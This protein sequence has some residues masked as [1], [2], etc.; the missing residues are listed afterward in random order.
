MERL[1]GQL[2]VVDMK[3]TTLRRGGR[4]G[5]L[6]LVSRDLTRCLLVPGIAPTLQAALD[7]WATVAPRLA[8]RA[9]TLELNTANADVMPFDPTQCAAPSAARVS[10]GGRQRLREPPGA[11][12]ARRAAPEMPRPPSR[13]GPDWCPL[14]WLPN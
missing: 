1:R 13:T 3:L 6:A 12:P 5:R 9:A 7:D 14:G 2:E 11:G 4:D 10:L 8:D